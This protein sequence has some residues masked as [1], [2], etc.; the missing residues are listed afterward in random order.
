MHQTLYFWLEIALSRRTLLAMTNHNDRLQTLLTTTNIECSSK[1]R[2]GMVNMAEKGPYYV[3]ILTNKYNRVL[4]T[5][6]TSDLPRRIYEH[7]TNQSN[8]T[9]RYHVHKLVY[10]EEYEQ[11]IDAITREKQIKAGSRQKKIDLVNSIN[12]EWKDLME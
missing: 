11:I 4:Y 2:D 5:G 10:M 9:S 6:V 7:Q 1:R 3:Y 12:P 8:F